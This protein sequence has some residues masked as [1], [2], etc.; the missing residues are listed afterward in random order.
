MA[1][2]SCSE[3]GHQVSS[4]APTCPSCGAPVA[5]ASESR[6]AGASLSTVQETS[7]KLKVHILISSI[8]FWVSLIW[9]GV[10]VNAA[11]ENPE[12]P[13][14]IA[15]LF[16]TVGIIWYVVAKLRIWWHHK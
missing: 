9:V 4:A 1:L 15:M 3:C 12:A 8:I 6:A 10:S 7:K 13:I 5:G 16:L 14:G 11:K 2:I